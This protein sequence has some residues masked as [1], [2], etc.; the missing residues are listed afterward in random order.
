MA[1]T[2]YAALSQAKRSLFEP[3]KRGP[4]AVI[5]RLSWRTGGG[6]ESHSGPV[7][8]AIC[9]AIVYV[10]PDVDADALSA[11]LATMPLCGAVILPRNAPRCADAVLTKA[12]FYRD[13][14]VGAV[15][16]A[17]PATVA[18]VPGVDVRRE[19]GDL[20]PGDLNSKDLNPRELVM[21]DPCMPDTPPFYLDRL[22]AR[23]VYS[24]AGNA[25]AVRLTAFVG[26]HRVAVGAVF[27]AD[28]PVAVVTAASLLEGDHA[29]IA[30]LSGQLGV[31]QGAVEHVAVRA[32][33]TAALSAIKDTAHAV[34][35]VSKRVALDY[36]EIP[37]ELLAAGRMT[38]EFPAYYRFTTDP[39]LTTS[40]RVNANIALRCTFDTPFDVDDV[41]A[42]HKV[43]EAESQVHGSHAGGGRVYNS[44]TGKT[45]WDFGACSYMGIEKEPTIVRPAAEA[46][47]VHGLSTVSSRAYL[48][49]PLLAAI[50]EKVSR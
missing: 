4:E 33:H 44:D 15:L 10:S 14:F 39:S 12:G 11:E 7:H 17:V 8:S 19:T 48:E 32:I 43:W 23:L 47:A 21:M 6:C 16:A 22:A 40:L 25:R 45:M 29:K 5:R 27:C 35:L 38:A 37:R 30:T 1:A 2:A 13:G 24:G 18:P 34:V 31:Y 42:G 28:G 46:Y 41:Y 36:D 26:D 9:S 49:N 50:E 3:S 20:K